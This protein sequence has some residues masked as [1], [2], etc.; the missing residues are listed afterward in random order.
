M[1][2]FLFNELGNSIELT[3]E[4]VDKKITSTEQE[5]IIYCSNCGTQITSENKFCV[6]CGTKI[7]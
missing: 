3:K 7:E 4:S 2:I 1:I 5:K 6:N